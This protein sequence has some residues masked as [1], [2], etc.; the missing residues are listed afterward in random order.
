MHEAADQRR[1]PPTHMRKIAFAANVERAARSDPKLAVTAAVWDT[2]PWLLGV[3]G[4]V[5]D[6]RTGETLPPDPGLY[7]SRETSVAPAPPGTDAPI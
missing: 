2:D 6:L 5:V 3:P 7:I 1:S 4:G